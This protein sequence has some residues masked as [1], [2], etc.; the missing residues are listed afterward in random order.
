M[1]VGCTAS[2]SHKCVELAAEY[3]GVFAAVG[4]QPN[5]V[6][7]AGSGDWAIIE[8]L[9]TKPGV[10]AIGET[11]ARPLLGFNAL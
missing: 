8:Q 9:A 2:D 4:I 6:A 1:A 10:V 5:Y 11:G 7:E 3:E